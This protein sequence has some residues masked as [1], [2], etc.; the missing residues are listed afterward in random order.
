MATDQIRKTQERRRKAGLVTASAIIVLS[1]LAGACGGGRADSSDGNTSTTKT[2][3]ATDFGT[4]PS[5]CGNGEAKGATQKGVTDTSITIGYGDDA[6]YPGSPGLNKEI[7]DAMKAMI[8][9]CNDQGGIN[10]RQIIGDYHDAAILN[11]NNAV[12]DAC[13]KNFMLVGSGFAL[14]GAGEA[15]RLSCKLAAVPTYTVSPE[16]A[17]AT[18]MVQ[19]TPNPVNWYDASNAFLLAEKFPTQVKKAAIFEGNFAATID[20]ADKAEIAYEQAGWQFMDNCRLQYAIA[21][22][23]TYLPFIQRLKDCGAEVVY[24]SGSPAPIFQNVLDA[25]KQSDFSPIWVTEANGYTEQFAKWN[26]SGNADK[27]YTRMT[28]YPFEQAADHP[29]TAKY[30]ELVKANGGAISLL[31]AQATAAFL[32]WA[33]GAKTCGS[34][35]TSDCV[36]AELAKVHDYDAGG[37]QSPTD[38]GKNLPGNCGMVVNLQGT[39]WKQ[40][41]PTT[42]GTQACDPKYLVK[43]S[44]AVVDRANLDANGNSRPKG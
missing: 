43:I 26:T 14:D 33:Q 6:G 17:N 23:S 42:L 27:V 21:G 25:A 22:E 8:K 3:T 10:G 2:A 32:L 15:T 19:P 1:L 38:P 39:T 36:L 37:L 4:M 18:L 35:L 12:T 29:A 20:S 11:V 44:G 31:G 5:P 16:F 13:T 24:F 34:N 41:L 30:I 40:V 28:Y 7:A 9:W